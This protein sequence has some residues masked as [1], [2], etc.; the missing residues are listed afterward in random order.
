MVRR[1]A[2]ARALL[3]RT[4]TAKEVAEEF[5]ITVASARRDLVAIRELWRREMIEDVD[6]VVARD[7]AELG[8]VKREAWMVY[9]ESL[10]VGEETVTEAE[11][12]H[13][14][15]SVHNLRKVETMNPKGNL[16]ALKT[17]VQCIEKKRKILGLDN[18]A[19][20]LGAGKKISFTVKIGDRVLVSEASTE[21]PDDIL[22]AEVVELDSTGRVLPSGL[23]DG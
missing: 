12:L 3:A 13:K 16:A 8:M 2:I 10:E 7:L 20:G 15:G 17:V 18:E 9:Q 5:S 21:D 22:D 23:E 6:V 19:S 4:L 1:R 14:D 11:V